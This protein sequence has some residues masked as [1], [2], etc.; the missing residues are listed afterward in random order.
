MNVLKREVNRFIQWIS[1]AL[2]LQLLASRGRCSPLGLLISSIPAYISIYVY[3]IKTLDCH[4]GLYSESLISIVPLIDR[5]GCIINHPSLHWY[6]RNTYNLTRSDPL[7]NPVAGLISHISCTRMSGTEEMLRKHKTFAK[8]R[9]QTA[10]SLTLK[11]Q[12][13]GGE[14]KER[15]KKQPSCAEYIFAKFEA[16]GIPFQ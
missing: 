5:C 12:G 15:K 7:I 8:S 3:Y 1:V 14:G 10:T 13:E 11:I 16:K 6:L 4:A 2:R 9:A